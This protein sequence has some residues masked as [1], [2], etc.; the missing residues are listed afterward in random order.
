MTVLAA[1]EELRTSTTIY[2]GDD[3]VGLRTVSCTIR[4]REGLLQR[5]DVADT[6]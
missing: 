5:G 4:V 3:V 6:L 1:V 2:F